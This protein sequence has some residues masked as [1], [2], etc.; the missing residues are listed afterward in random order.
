VEA[1]LR[2]EAVL[3]KVSLRIEAAPSLPPIMGDRVQL[4]QCILNLVLNAFD[5]IAAAD[6]RRRE[7]LLRVV[8]EEAGWVTV[9]VR[10]TGRGIDPSVQGRLFE[11]FV[12]TKPHGMGMGLLVTRSIV[13]NH[14]GKTSGKSNADVGATFTFTLP[15]IGEQQRK[16]MVGS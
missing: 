1:L 16:E 10:D 13:E 9:S 3:R 14:G 7:V 4:E 2:S 11:P 6:T 5:S 15:T 8:Q 12:T